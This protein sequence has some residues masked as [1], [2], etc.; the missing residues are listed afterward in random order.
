MVMEGI[1]HPYGE[2][3]LEITPN[4]DK[5][6]NKEN[7]PIFFSH[8]NWTMKGICVVASIVQYSGG[9]RCTVVSSSVRCTSASKHWWC[10]V[11]I[12]GG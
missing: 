9:L 11:Y 7:H 3:D 2:K 8:M 1:H 10:T 12:G 5:T 6:H 4:L